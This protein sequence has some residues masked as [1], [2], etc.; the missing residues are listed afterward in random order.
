[1][2][3]IKSERLRQALRHAIRQYKS[4]IVIE[5]GTYLGKGSTRIIAESFELAP[6]E[7]F[8]TIEISPRFSE[9]ARQHLA[10]LEFVE[11]IWGLSVGRKQAETFL[12]NDSLLWEAHHY[13]IAVENPEDPVSFYLAEINGNMSGKGRR[14]SECYADSSEIAPDRLLEKLLSQYRDYNPLIALDSAGG[15]GWLEFLEVIRLQEARPFV[16]FLD[17]VNHVKHYRSLKYVQSSADFQMID[18]DIKD[19]W[20]VA[21]FRPCFSSKS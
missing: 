7:R 8:Y 11:V 6:P 21:A 16:L 14:D 10:D 1:M 2:E 4:R 18:C 5:T 9:I 20:L 15:I 17:D 19:G 12:Q 3:V 13:N